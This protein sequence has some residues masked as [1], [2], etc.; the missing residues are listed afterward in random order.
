MHRRL[1]PPGDAF[2]QPAP[3]SVD[4]RVR[5]KPHLQGQWSTH[6][7]LERAYSARLALAFADAL[8]VDAPPALRRTLRDVVKDAGEVHSLVEDSLHVSLSRP[9]Q[10]W[11]GQRTDFL[12]SIRSVIEVHQR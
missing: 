6:L 7:Y 8:S 9:L 3:E 11:G 12:K 10:L 1:R 4:G 2:D 5:A